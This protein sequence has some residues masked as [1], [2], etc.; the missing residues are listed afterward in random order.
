MN[1]F[2]RFISFL[3]EKEQRIEIISL[4]AM[5]SVLGIIFYIYHPFPFVFPDTGAYVVAAESDTLNVFRPMG[6]S[7]YL[8]LIHGISNS[9]VFV[10]ITS[11]TLNAI[12]SLFFLYSFKYLYGLQNKW[13]FYAICAC[14][15]LSPTILF[16]TNF[17]MSDGLFNT[18]TVL[19]ITTAIWMICNSN[20]IMVVIHL[21]SL[22]MLYNVRFAGMFFVPVSMIALYSTFKQKSIIIKSILTIL[23]VILLFFLQKE[24]RKEYKEITGVDTISGFSGWQ[25][26]NNASVLIPK[27]KQL[28]TNDFEKGKEQL[29]HK[30][31]ISCPDSIFT[32]QAALSTSLMW[33]QT[34]PFKQF[35]FFYMQSEK[36]PYAIAWAEVG[37]MYSAYAK[38]LILAYPFDFIKDFLIPSFISFFKF[39]EIGEHNNEFK[40]EVFYRNYYNIQMDTFKHTCD[41]FSKINPLRRVLHYIYW[42]VL[43]LSI[44]Y[45]LV[46][47]NKTCF[48]NSKWQILMMLLLYMI[49]YTAISSLASP[50]TTWRYAM[51]LYIPSIIFI[52]AIIN[53]A[54]SDFLDSRI[55]AK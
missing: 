53:I 12:V 33:E 44:I 10:F 52:G 3:S 30:F 37:D 6:Y 26:M 47:T 17:L 7:Y 40:N 11:Y 18:L 15:F 24:T 28:S 50:N 45:F 48:I 27:A 21:V 38:K 39:H 31:I 19:F 46:K 20:Y 13:I 14:V 9:I 25:L 22:A 51:P 43:T 16:G 23:P 36:K 5:I 42:I 35:T 8:Q 4:S 41:F 55:V 54:L 49:I 29:Y 34:S 1:N 2:R 32:T